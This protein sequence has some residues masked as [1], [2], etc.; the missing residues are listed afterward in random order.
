MTNLVSVVYIRSA[1]TKDNYKHHLHSLPYR[2]AWL[3]RISN[4]I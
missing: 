1:P 2:P 3:K 4:N